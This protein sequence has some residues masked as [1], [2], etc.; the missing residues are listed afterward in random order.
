MNAISPPILSTWCG[1]AAPLCCLENKSQVRMF[2]ENLQ[3][4][5]ESELKVRLSGRGSTTYSIDWK[6]HVTPLGRRIF[7]LRA[8]AHRT[9]DSEHSSAQSGWPT[10]TTRDFRDFCN[11]STSMRRKDGVLRKDV[12]TRV[13]WLH[14]YGEINFTPTLAQ[15]DEFARAYLKASRILMGYPPEWCE[16]AATGMPLIRG[17]QKSSSK[18]PLRL[19]EERVW[20][21]LL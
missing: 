12:L 10:P 20:A 5:V 1:P 16:C 17:R 15:M 19:S 7:R 4:Q 8:S 2:S 9:S 3:A 11:L 6:P 18:R 14:L 21:L 13:I